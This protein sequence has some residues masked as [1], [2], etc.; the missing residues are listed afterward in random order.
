MFGALHLFALIFGGL[1]LTMFFRSDTLPAWRPP[2]DEE[3]GGGGGGGSEPPPRPGGPP[4]TDAE[5][6][7]ARLREPGRLADRHPFPVRRPRHAP[8]REREPV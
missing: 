4:L 3:D 1:L 2:E 6:S 7:R 5:Q 8:E